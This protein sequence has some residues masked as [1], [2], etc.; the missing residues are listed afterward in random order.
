MWAA[1]P[2]DGWMNI[3]FTATASH[4]KSYKYKIY[5]VEI[6]KSYSTRKEMCVKVI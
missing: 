4:G 6:I 2:L 5:L 1:G 3:L